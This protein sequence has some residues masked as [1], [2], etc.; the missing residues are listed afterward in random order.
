MRA[1]KGTKVKNDGGDQMRGLDITVKRQGPIATVTLNRFTLSLDMLRE[2]REIASGFQDD[3][4][5]RIVILTGTSSF[6]S[7]GLDLKDPEIKKMLSG[8]LEERRERVLLGPRACRAWEETSPVTIAAIEGYCVGGG[9][10]LVIACDFRI[11]G[12]SAFLRI[13]EVGLGLNYSWGSIP[14]LLHLIG[15]AKT[16]HMIMLGERVSAETC[17]KWGLAEQVVPDGSSMEGAIAM[18]DKIL[19]KPPIPVA[20]TK[21]AVTV[22]AAALDRT[23]IY[24]DS[25]HRGGCRP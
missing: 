20:M 25:R 11:M 16:K 10:S 15:P 8:S 14:R 7:A 22:V 9:V 23:S 6:F 4:D 3:L 2:L 19:A 13:P 5:T 12:R 18:A 1:G 24:M 21:K 17:L